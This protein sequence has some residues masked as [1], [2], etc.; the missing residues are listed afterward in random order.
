ML[1]L[2]NRNYRWDNVNLV[3][4]ERGTAMLHDLP[5]KGDGIAPMCACRKYLSC[6]VSHVVDYYQEH[7]DSE[8]RVTNL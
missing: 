7:H 3:K 6:H 4:A 5:A 8:V 2:C 1:D